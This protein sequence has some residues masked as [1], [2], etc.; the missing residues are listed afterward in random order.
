M[1]KNRIFSLFICSYIIIPVML[2][3]TVYANHLED[4]LENGITSRANS[5]SKIAA[6][7]LSGIKAE[8]INNN[9]T[10]VNEIE[11]KIPG[12]ASGE[13]K[14][15]LKGYP[16]GKFEPEKEISRAEAAAIFSNLIG[17]NY[18][19]ENKI[20]TYTDVHKNH[21]AIEE[22]QLV[23]QQGLFRGYKDGL[24]KP[25]QK[26]TRAEFAAVVCNF[27]N[28]TENED[29][30]ISFNDIKGHWAER[31]IKALTQR[32]VISGYVDGTFRPQANI[33]RSESAVLINRALNRGPLYGAGQIFV[34]VPESY[35]AHKDIASGAMDYKY[36]IDENGHEIMINK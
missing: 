1:K 2:N 33:K 34:D 17:E 20:T 26:I 35:W 27:L 4:Y 32:K 29:K 18:T 30:I 24:F 25:E 31:D 19:G 13:H 28:I 8:I 6:L 16:G 36:V 3:Y 23:S 5:K 22:I 12:I 10:I 21:W 14:S 9:S 15:Y 7:Y 11:D